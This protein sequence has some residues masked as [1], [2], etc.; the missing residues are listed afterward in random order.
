MGYTTS[1]RRARAAERYADRCGRWKT[2]SDTSSGGQ[3]YPFFLAHQFNLPPEQFTARWAVADWLVEWKYD[4]IRGAGGQ[5]RRQGLDVVARRGTGDRAL[6][7]EIEALGEALPDGTVLD[8]E[9]LVWRDGRPSPLPLL[10]QRIGRKNLTKKLLPR[11]RWCFMAYDL[12]EQDGRT[13]AAAAARAP[14]GWKRCWR[15]RLPAVAGGDRRQLAATS[16]ASASSRASGRR[17]LHAQAHG[18]R[19][20]HRPHQ[21][22]GPVVEV[23]DRPMTI[24]C[25]LVYAQRGHGRRASVYTDYTFAVWNRRRDKEEAEAVLEAI[26]RKE[27]AQ[28]LQLVPFAKAYSGLTDEEFRQVDAIIRKTTIE[29]LR[30]GAQRQ[31][32]PGVRAGLRRHQPQQ[33]AQERHRGALPAHAAH[34][35]TTSRWTRPAA[36]SLPFQREVW[37]AMAEGRSGM[38]HATTGSGKTYAVWLGHAGAAA[39]PPAMGAR[40]RAAA[41]CGSRRCARWPRRHRCKALPSRCALA[42]NW[43]IGLRTGDT[44][45]RAR[46]RRTAACPPCWSPRRSRCR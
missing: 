11:R 20:R 40:R 23:E 25:V 26:A 10:Q 12:L 16:P 30:A 18:R 37:Q 43:T 29:K 5:A 22:R 39:A 44:Q 3:P 24:D 28:P 45:R 19:L 2:A 6:S 14:R 33:P 9:I 4:G 46:A 27:P 17:G 7:P 15:H 32:E 35:A 21:G 42:P 41:R 34:G 36:G 8:G 1:A 31:A 38:L 13:C